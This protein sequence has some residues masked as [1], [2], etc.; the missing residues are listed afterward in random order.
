MTFDAFET[1]DGSP[2]ELLTW[3]N[4]SII[5]RNTNAVKAIV[6]GA[7]T[8][9]PLAYTRNAFAQSKDNDDTNI[10]MTVPSSFSIVDLY[11]GQLTSSLT[12]LTIER[13]H[14]DD[15]P[16][17]E[18]Q[19]VWSGKVV[20]IERAEDDVTMLLQPLSTGSESTPP[21]TF[22][23][24]CNAFLFQSPGCNLSANDFRFI[25]TLSAI[26]ATGTILTFP[27]LRVQAETLDLALGGPTGPLS[28]AELDI[29]WQGGFVTTGGGE[30]RDIVE[31]NVLADPDKVR[32]NIPLR[33]FAVSDGA[34]VFAGCDL[35]IATCHKK[36]NNVLNFQ[37]YAYIPEVDP[38]NTE[39]PPGTR[40]SSGGFA[41]P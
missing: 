13:F 21:D 20:A 25:A 30:T 40:T 41:G 24:V 38:A 32:I 12:L 31:G 6:V 15:T 27:G 22:S 28:S 34:N 26:D 16:V 37:G 9:V 11:D 29:Y 23:A 7:N 14:K 8:F 5:T 33:N 4:S 19:N 36:F 10:Q 1:S 2:V 39:L 35:S 18:V 3:Q 17:P